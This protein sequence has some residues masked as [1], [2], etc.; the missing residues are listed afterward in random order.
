MSENEFL[1]KFLQTAKPVDNDELKPLKGT[2]RAVIKEISVQPPDQYREVACWRVNLQI[3]E[4][5]E[6]DRG[7]NRYLNKRYNKDEKGLQSFLNDMH[8]AGI[9]V[10]RDSV[11]ALE[12]SFP[13]LQDKTL[14]VRTWV[15]TIKKDKGV[16]LPESE[17]KEVQSLV[18]TGEKRN[19][20]LIGKGS[21]VPF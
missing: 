17:W 9:E 5:L 18:I 14:L 3:A 11:S 13:G 2:Y 12:A 21:Q 20:K 19:K 10:P 1:D 8:T 15:G 4:T 16:D 6:G 7:N